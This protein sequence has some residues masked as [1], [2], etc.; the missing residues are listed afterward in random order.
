MNN[1]L[2]LNSNLLWAHE[3]KS[4][5]PLVFRVLFLIRSSYFTLCVLGSGV[6][7]VVCGLL[8]NSEKPGWLCARDTLGLGSFKEGKHAPLSQS[9]T[10]GAVT[11]SKSL[12]LQHLQHIISST[13]VLHITVYFVTVGFCWLVCGNCTLESLIVI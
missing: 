11:L 4:A 10:P 5:N 3:K 8:T 6:S 7:P 2:N 12:F 9:S 13:V 1:N